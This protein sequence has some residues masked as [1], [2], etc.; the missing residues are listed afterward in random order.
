MSAFVAVFNRDGRPVEA[1]VIEQMLDATPEYAVHGQSRWVDRQ[2]G[3]GRQHF[4]VLPE[5]VGEVQPLFDPDSGC[6]LVADVRLDNRGELAQALGLRNNPAPPLTDSGLLFAAY[7]RW[8]AGCAGRLLGD[9]AFAVWDPRPRTLFAAR[10]PMGSRGLSYFVTDAVALLASSVEHLLAHPM[11]VPRINEAKVAEYLA[12]EW[13]NQEETFFQDVYDLPP[14]HW[15]MISPER[16]ERREYCDLLPRAPIRYRDPAAYAD[17]FRELVTEA[18][19]CRLRATGRIGVSL[20]GGLDSTF[21]AAVAARLITD[22][23]AAPDLTGYS[24]AFERHVECD[25]RQYIEPLVARLGIK[26]RYVW[27][28]DLWTFREIDRWPVYRDFIFW[29]AYAW[30]PQAVREAAHRDDCRVLLGGYYGDSLMAGEWAWTSTLLA[31]G[32]IAGLL[33]ELWVA[34]RELDWRAEALNALRPWTPG[35]FRRT[36]RAMRSG[37]RGMACHGL[38]PALAKRVNLEARRASYERQ[39]ASVPPTIR[40]FYRSLW[41]NLPAQGVASVQRQY[42]RLGMELLSPYADRRLVE[43]VLA[44]PADRLG[45]PGSGRNRW[46]QR[47]AMRGLAPELVRLRPRKTTFY[48]LMREGL[49]EKECATVAELLQNPRMVALGYVDGAWFARRPPTAALAEGEVL[50]LWLCLSL[51]LWLR[52]YGLSRT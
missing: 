34:R 9:F 37:R 2:V 40:R 43:F 20:S 23:P 13:S 45:K 19:R 7:R 10:D 21:L 14:G 12:V 46:L 24:Y 48:P 1:E 41:T 28:D 30:L 32:R 8:G 15:L 52:R 42:N 51:E 6:V 18:V 27:C 11:V 5:E 49:F 39:A 31:E 29:D 17:R 35:W 26:S 47:E 36:W 4:W 33:R 38:A 25:E 50:F 16:I 22:R 44:I 3:L